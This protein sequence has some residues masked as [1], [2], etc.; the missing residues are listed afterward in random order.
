[1]AQKRVFTGV[2]N[3]KT[4]NDVKSYNDEMT[5]LI[6]EGCT[7][8]QASSSTTIKTVCD[9]CQEDKCVCE[10]DTEEVN[11]FPGFN[12]VSETHFLDELITNDY[13]KDA[14]NFEIVKNYHAKYLPM[15]LDKIKKMSLKE[16]TD[17]LKELDDII[18]NINDTNDNLHADIDE[19]GKNIAHLQDK[20][21][22]LKRGLPVVDEYDSVYS[23]IQTAAKNRLN[24]FDLGDQ[25]TCKRTLKEKTSDAVGVEEFMKFLFGN[26]PFFNFR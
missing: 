7:D 2:I 19:V 26:N 16:V 23:E 6:N 5:K 17:Y 9:A 4:F 22:K 15:I 20:L 24:E 25:V 1:M 12:P 14:K 13:E 21:T 10:A 18:D 3:G 8:I 11:M